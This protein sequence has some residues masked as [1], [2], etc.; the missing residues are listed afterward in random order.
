MPDTLKDQIYRAEEHLKHLL[1]LRDSDCDQVSPAPMGIG[2]ARVKGDR[3]SRRPSLR[4]DAE[5]NVGYHREQ[6]D[7]QDR[8]VAFF[9]ENPAFDQFIQLVREGVIQF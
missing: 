4:E 5:K 9:R 3:S 1:S 6:A 2:E 7:K 8:A